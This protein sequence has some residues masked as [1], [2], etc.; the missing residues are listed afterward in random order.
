MDK[1]HSGVFEG[2]LPIG[3]VVTT[4]TGTKNL[5]IMGF[6]VEKNDGTG[7]IYDYCAVLFPEGFSDGNHVYFL[8]HSDIGSISRIGYMN[9]DGINFEDTLETI[10]KRK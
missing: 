3:S 8:N 4:K 10:L 1:K 7:E 9:Y 6:G 2:V 5:M